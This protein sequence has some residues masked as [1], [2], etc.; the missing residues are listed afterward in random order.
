MSP[1]LRTD[2]KPTERVVEAARVPLDLMTR[3]A[4]SG[5]FAD[6]V[7]Y[8]RPGRWT[9]AGGVLG[10]VVLDDG[11][12]HVRWPGREPA[13]VPYAGSRPADALRDAFAAAP[14][15]AW[16]AYGWIAFEFAAARPSGRLAHFVV[17]RVEV[18]VED[19]RARVTGAD[20][21]DV[22]RVADLLTADVPPR[23]A[24]PSPVDVRRGGDAYRA[25]VARAVGDIA[26]GRYQKVIV[27][28]RLDVP[29]P[30]DV[31]ATYA[32]GRAANTPARSFLLDLSGFQA[33]GFS[34]EVL[35]SVD[36]D[37]RVMTQPLAGTR[38]FGSGGDADARTRKELETDPK[39]IFEHAVSVRTSQEELYRVCDPDSVHV[40]GFMTVKERGSVQHL[41]SS[42]GGVLAPGRTC[43]DALDALFPGVTA[44]G[45]PKADAIEAIGGLEERRGLYAGAVAAV[46]HT[47][48]L[49]S[50]LV[51]R[52]LYNRDG[53]A[54][55]RAGAGI[56]SG[57]TPDREYE[58]TC[59]KLSSIAP[60]VVPLA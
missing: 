60:Y 17:P 38:A 24:A 58:E 28:R 37:G 35:A 2:D 47:G 31:V 44:S 18:D 40:T 27:S 34:P 16:N 25:R 48:A 29:Y 36:E 39:E 32:R 56:V 14:L 49:D 4:G 9:F 50:A 5:L 30:V 10:E 12:V 33:T 54:W 23:A 1:G 52:A 45:I 19:G 41:G 26:A 21:R 42:V 7:V 46:S 22:E 51:L 8:E 55:L 6:H 15:P 57:S 43:W 13:T 59:E 3:L 11:A 53:R 20:P